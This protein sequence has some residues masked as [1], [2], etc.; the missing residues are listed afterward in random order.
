MRKRRVY[1][2]LVALVMVGVLVVV[3]RTRER[4][5][6]YGGTWQKGFS[7]FDL[8]RGRT[9]PGRFWDLRLRRG[10][11]ETGETVEV[12]L[13]P[14]NTQLKSS[15]NERGSLVPAGL[16]LPFSTHRLIHAEIVANEH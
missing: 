10:R 6:E 14:A 3:F 7:I 9:K 16:S 1:L 4:E 5:P 8:R 13:Q 12:F 15:V 2:M 11:R